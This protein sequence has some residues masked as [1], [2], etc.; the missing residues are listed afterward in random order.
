MSL[1]EKDYQDAATILGIE[2]AAIKAVSEVESAGSGF[3]DD[4]HVRILFERHKFHHYTDGDYDKDHPDISNPTAGGYGAGGAHQ[5]DRFNEAFGLDPESA[6]LSTSWGRFQIMGFNF[7][8]AGFNS[9]G[10]FVDAMKQGEGEQLKAF[11]KLIKAWGLGAELKAHNWASFARQYNGGDYRANKYDTKLAAAYEK[12]SQETPAAVV[13][14]PSVVAVTPVAQPS[15]PVEGGGVNDPPKQITRS[16]WSRI[17][18]A[19]GVV[20]GALAAI[21]GWLTNHDAVLASGVICV[22]VILLAL[23][24]RKAIL[25]YLRLEIASDS[26]KINVK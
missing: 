15:T 14:V 6:M 9:V 10:E 4:G 8:P 16:L 25:D 13:E 3:L 12:F 20:A 1:T 22:T 19:V 21:K 2:P 7:R 11:V 23:I 18:G 17:Y 24:F 26:T 5:W